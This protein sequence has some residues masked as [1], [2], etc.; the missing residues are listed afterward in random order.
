MY[1]NFSEKLKFTEVYVL[2]HKLFFFLHES[3]PAGPVIKTKKGQCRVKK[4]KTTLVQEIQ[5]P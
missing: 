5:S 3:Q 2:F 1:F 4:G